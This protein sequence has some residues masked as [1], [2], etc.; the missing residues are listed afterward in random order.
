MVKADNYNDFIAKVAN[1]VS[2]GDTTEVVLIEHFNFGTQKK[3][4]FDGINS[5]VY[6]RFPFEKWEKECN[7]DVEQDIDDRVM[8]LSLPPEKEYEAELY[9]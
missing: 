8:E 7:A 5:H 6:F 4:H 2:R 1:I 3:I 9:F